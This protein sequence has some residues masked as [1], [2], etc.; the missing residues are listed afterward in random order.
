MRKEAPDRVLLSCLQLLEQKILGMIFVQYV[1]IVNLTKIIIEIGKMFVYNVC[2][3]V[4]ST[5]FHERSQYT[6]E[7]YS[8][9]LSAGPQR[10]R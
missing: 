8:Q 9:Y 10:Q 4:K 7:H 1:E 5:A 3:A 2:I 6:H